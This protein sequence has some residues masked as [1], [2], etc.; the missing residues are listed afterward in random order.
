MQASLVRFSHPAIF[1]LASLLIVPVPMATLRAA[2]APTAQSDSPAPPST[3]GSAAP[4][5]VDPAAASYSVG[6]SFATQ[7]REGG[8][9]PG[10]VEDALVRG[11]HDGL[12]GK[13]ISAADRSQAS[14]FLKGAYEAL[15]ERN[16]AT[17]NS[18]LA[19]NARKQGVNTT[20]SGLQYQ[21]LTPG[22]PSQPMAGPN[23]R[24]TVQYRGSLLD[25][26][27]FDSSYSRG[28]PAIIRPSSTIAGWREALAL[29]N[30]G[31]KWRVFVPP[32]LGY[33]TTPP[34]VIPTNSVLVFE[35]EVLAIDPV[36]GPAPAPA[37]PR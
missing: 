13:P 32:E 31:A 17:A 1:T 6:L 5:A 7:W 4:A 22:D 35:I 28:K 11:I 37:A 20:A 3:P 21:V 27:E 2:A 34:P 12:G 18:F 36:A 26:T 24:V 33:G 16:K 19:S 23:D 25:G 14:A 10:L 30:R 8:L 15:S 9:V 29:M